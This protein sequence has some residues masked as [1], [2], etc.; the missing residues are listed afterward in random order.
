[1]ATLAFGELR[2]LSDGFT[3]RI[4]VSD[5]G[6]RTSYPLI[7]I[8]PKDEVAARTRCTAMAEMA[9]RLRRA[10]F[11]SDVDALM[12]QA[13]KARSGKAWESVVVAVEA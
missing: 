2:H 5:N 10:G 8:A 3:A 9:A 13:A 12:R 11:S 4:R 1:M 6:K 7:G